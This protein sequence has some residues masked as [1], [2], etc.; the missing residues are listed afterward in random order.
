VDHLPSLLPHGAERYERPHRPD[1]GLLFKLPTCGSQ[2]IF[3]AFGDPLWDGPGPD[4]ATL[5]EGASGMGQKELQAFRCKAIQQ[6]AR[7]GFRGLQGVILNP[8]K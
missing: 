7:A 8:Q 3:P 5:P 6:K 1:S 2:Q 4:I